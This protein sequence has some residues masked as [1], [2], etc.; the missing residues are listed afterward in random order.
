[1]F[2]TKERPEIE[3]IR[4]LETKHI[5]KF[6]DLTLGPM[7]V[8]NNSLEMGDDGLGRKKFRTSRNA[9][10]VLTALSVVALCVVSDGRWLDV[11]RLPSEESATQKK[12]RHNKIRVG[13]GP[14]S[15][16]YS[17]PAFES[18]ISSAFFHL[19]WADSSNKRR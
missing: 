4:E 12:K 18:R 7:V 9:V 17:G 3:S 16:K 11:Y 8:L 14:F 2:P 6:G 5:K 19:S 15:L 1:L 13:R 10:V